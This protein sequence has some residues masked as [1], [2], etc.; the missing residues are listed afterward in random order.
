MTKIKSIKDHKAKKKQE[1][2]PAELPEY[3]RCQETVNGMPCGCYAFNTYRTFI[4]QIYLTL[5][6]GMIIV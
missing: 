6:K 2:K 5:Y 1:T 4:H 3:Y